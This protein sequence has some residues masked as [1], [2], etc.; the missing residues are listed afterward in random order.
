MVV[1]A[2]A[3][4]AAAAAAVVVVVVVVVVVTLRYTVC[5]TLCERQ[6]C[7]S[8]RCNKVKLKQINHTHCA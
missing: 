1:V 2:A 8:H 7:M 5:Y 4:A 3:A 6:P